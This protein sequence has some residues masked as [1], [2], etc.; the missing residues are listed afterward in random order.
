MWNLQ[1]I[2]GTYIKH[3]SLS[4]RAK[5]RI[6]KRKQ[7]VAECKIAEYKEKPIPKTFLSE[8][9]VSDVSDRKAYFKEMFY[10]NDYAYLT[11]CKWY[12]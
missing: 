10:L 5:R 1:S 2:K 7:K 12:W 4:E 8:S 6:E 11:R 3:I 9:D